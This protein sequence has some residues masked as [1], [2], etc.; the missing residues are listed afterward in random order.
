M[1]QTSIGCEP[2]ASQQN[3]FN[4]LKQTLFTLLNSTEDISEMQDYMLFPLVLKTLPPCLLTLS[5][6]MEQSF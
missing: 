2:P 4:M 1:P 5:A 3:T 6:N